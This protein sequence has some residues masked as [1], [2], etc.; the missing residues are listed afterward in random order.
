MSEVSRV[1]TVVVSTAKTQHKGHRGMIRTVGLMRSPIG[2]FTA[3][4]VFG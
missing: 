4:V 2:Y 1:Q 3:V